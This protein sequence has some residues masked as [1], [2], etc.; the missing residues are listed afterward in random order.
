M[1]E[2]RND[3]LTRTMFKHTQP[4]PWESHVQWL[5]A[6]L[7]DSKYVLYIGELPSGEAVGSCRFDIGNEKAHVSLNLN[8]SMRG[9]KL[10]VPLLSAAILAF[11][12]NH[13]IPLLA[14]IKKQ[15]I[16]SRRCFTLCGFELISETEIYWHYLLPE[17]RLT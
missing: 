5:S 4:V 10:S 6:T 12:E 9:K 17:P 13:R 1:W 2:W 8:P 11:Y 7:Q 16:A 14:E 15:N 3:P